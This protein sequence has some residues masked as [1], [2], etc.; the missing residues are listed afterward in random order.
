MN[1]LSRFTFYVSRFTPTHHAM[2]KKK[3]LESKAPVPMTRGQLSRAQREQQRIRN[4]YTAGIVLGTVVMLVLAFAV[5]STFIIKPNA[6]VASVNG[7][8]INRA[9][10]DKLRRWNLYQE[11]QPQ[12]L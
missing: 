8:K 10:Y 4:L 7:V 11:V 6:E 9:T 12:A 1:S 2:A 5:V 3:K